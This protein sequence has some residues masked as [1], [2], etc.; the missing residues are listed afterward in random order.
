[1]SVRFCALGE[2]GGSIVGALP[3]D[4][5]HISASVGFG[6]AN[7]RSDVVLIQ[8]LLNQVPA[9][10]GSPANPLKVDGIVG[11]L[12]IAAIRRFQTANLGFNDGRIDPGGGTLARLSALT[13]QQGPSSPPSSSGG[14]SLGFALA[15]ASAAAPKPT[16]LAAAIAATPTAKLWTSAATLH[17]SGLQQGLIASG[18]AI[19]L[20]SIFDIVN[21]HFHL[22][23]DPP[24]LFSNLGKAIGVFNRIS[25]MLSDTTTFYREGPATAKSKFAD[26]PMGGFSQ[27]EPNHHI[28]IR[29][30]YPDCGPNCQAAMLVHEGAHFCGGLNEIR[31]FAHEF[32]VPNGEPQDGSTHNYAQM[33]ADEGLKN[34]A[35]YAAFAI[36]AFFLID[37]RFGLDKKSQ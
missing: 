16:P 37:L 3:A 2:R 19:F 18:G 33:T 35:S 28:T 26:A 30:Q 20:P 24:N 9:G 14:L 31:H 12:T 10:N 27:P 13:S 29:T 5:P 32:P 6:G 7:V 36:H 4:G 1:M 34:A 15:G 25:T 17:L 8:S 22:D 23:R 21:T 11:P